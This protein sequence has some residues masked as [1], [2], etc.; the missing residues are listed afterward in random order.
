MDSSKRILKAATTEFAKNGFEGARMDRIA[1]RARVNKALIYY[2]FGSK[3]RLYHR[4]LKEQVRDVISYLKA[5]IKETHCL[6]DILLALA[7]K[8]HEA[9]KA[10]SSFIPM[11]LREMATGGKH[12]KDILSHVIATEV[13]FRKTL[14]GVIEE[15]KRKGLYRNIDCRH[16][17]VSF[18]GMN[19]FYLLM[20]PV[21]N[22]IWDIK[23][24]KLFRLQRPGHIVDLFINGLKSR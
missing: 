20:A 10:D 18:V 14:T 13:D 15:G 1:R 24:E 7:T 17:M 6:E 21:I 4:V 9:L 23:D 2:H 19:L 22:E 12:V 8:Y 5:R 16:A 3:Q 11:L